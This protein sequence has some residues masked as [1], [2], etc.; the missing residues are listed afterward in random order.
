MEPIAEQIAARV[1]EVLAGIQAGVTPPGASAPYHY[2]PSSVIRFAGFTSSCLDTTQS[3]IYVVSPD[4]RER[5]I[6]GNQLIDATKFFDLALATKHKPPQAE[7]P[8]VNKR[9]S[10]LASERALK[11]TRMQADVE[12]ALTGVDVTLG[13][14]ALGVW[15]TEITLWDEGAEDTF[16]D[17]W[18]ITYGRLAVY[19]KHL[20]S[21]P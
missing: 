10:P 12:K 1:Q 16:V 6:D 4:H 9:P 20:R 14:S 3:T 7:A 13:L 21:R 15:L 18:A 19:Y 5:K 2:T 8:L 17:G 11:Q